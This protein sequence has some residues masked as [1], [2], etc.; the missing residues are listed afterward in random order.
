MFAARWPNVLMVL[1]T[2]CAVIANKLKAGVQDRSVAWALVRD[3]W[4][5]KEEL[6]SLFFSE[7]VHAMCFINKKF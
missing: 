7:N 3:A 4:V 2:D 6:C 1:E 5:D